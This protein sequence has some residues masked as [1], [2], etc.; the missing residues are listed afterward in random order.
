M[1]NECEKEKK[2][3]KNLYPVLSN[4]QSMLD[5]WKQAQ[6]RPQKAWWEAVEL[7]E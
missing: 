2:E 5:N 1:L 3:R 7:D 4:S 6:W